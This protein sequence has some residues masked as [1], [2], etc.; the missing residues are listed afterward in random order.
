M[1]GTLERFFWNNATV[2][3]LKAS[4]SMWVRSEV[5]K[6]EQTAQNKSR[7]FCHREQI[8]GAQR[9]LL[10]AFT[11]CLLTSRLILSNMLLLHLF[12][13]PP[14]TSSLIPPMDENTRTHP[15]S[16]V[17]AGPH[18]PALYRFFQK[19]FNLSHPS[20]FIYLPRPSTAAPQ[21]HTRLLSH[22]W[23]LLWHQQ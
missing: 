14:S 16:I 22:A 5:G 4:L 21:S 13:F 6:F 2:S 23:K 17:S 19:C 7:V 8:E 1:T 20:F 11:S 3:P 9:K 18:P 12:L 15:A 10:L